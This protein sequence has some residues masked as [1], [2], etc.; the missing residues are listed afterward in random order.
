MNK[1]EI[2][3]F[4]S[5]DRQVSKENAAYALVRVYDENGR[6]MDESRG[7]VGELSIQEP[8]LENELV[9]ET[10]GTNVQEQEEQSPRRL[11]CSQCGNELSLDS[12]FCN[13]CGAP[14]AGHTVD[15]NQYVSNAG[16][17]S[18]V[19]NKPGFKIADT[20]Q[21]GR[22]ISALC[23]FIVW[24]ATFVDINVYYVS[25]NFWQ[26]AADMDDATAWIVVGSVVILAAILLQI[27]K[28]PAATGMFSLMIIPIIMFIGNM[29][30]GIGTIIFTG[31]FAVIVVGYLLAI[32]IQPIMRAYKK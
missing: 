3:Y 32:F 12:A 22:W 30:N 29:Y 26:Y 1:T 16:S 24:I 15:K 9:P 6:L 4:D 27:A 18:P 13:R 10:E 5:N 21:A 28:M 31:P 19:V 17:G 11:F 2:L 23:M 20:Q 7:D 8:D 14:V 25:G